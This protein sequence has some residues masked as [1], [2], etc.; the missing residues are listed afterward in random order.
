MPWV[1]STNHVAHSENFI[2]STL[3]QFANN[4]GFA[5]AICDKDRIVG[6]VGLNR[7]DR[8]NSIAVCRLG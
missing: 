6:I 5:A 4:E 1:D 3:Q 8:D 2:R 7:I